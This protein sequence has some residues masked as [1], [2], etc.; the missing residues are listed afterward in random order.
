MTPRYQA[1]PA[2][3][4]L[5]LAILVV[6][7]AWLN[8]ISHAQGGVQVSAT[9]PIAAE[10]GTINLNVKVTGKGFKN[11]ASAK[12]FVTGTTNPGGVTVNSTTFVSSTEVTVNITVADTATISNFDIYVVNSDGR[13]GKG[14]E[15][16]AVTPKGNQLQDIGVSACFVYCTPPG[17]DSASQAVYTACIQQNRIRMDVDRDYVNGQEGID[18][19]FHIVS[20]S[21]D[22]TLNLL[23]LPTRRTVI[24]L[25][26]LTTASSGQMIPSWRSTSQNAK[27][28]F[29]V[30][31]AYLAKT[32][33]GGGPCD[34]ETD[35]A[36]TID[37]DGDNATYYLAWF[38]LSPRP[39]NSPEIT[40]RVNVHYEVVAGVETWTVTPLENYPSS[41]RIVAGLAKSIK[42]RSEAAGQYL[43]PFTLTV[44]LQ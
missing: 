21:N 34:M 20:G 24:D 11:G 2:I 33:C 5:C 14:T 16:F 15:L 31:R 19:V 40:S 44:K 17:S 12:W 43:V 1:S 4:F 42:N 28:F 9:D 37:I 32:L 38:P 27:V 10:Q 36:S 23:T 26:D 25:Y 6:L 7:T 29:N 3:L 39:V 13:G 8:P 41:G 22:L 18:A 30:R 35:M